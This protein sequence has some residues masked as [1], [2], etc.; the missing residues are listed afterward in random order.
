MQTKLLTLFSAQETLFA[1]DEEGKK[2]VD[3]EKNKVE[4]QAGKA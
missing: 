2:V 1:D 4:D 3:V